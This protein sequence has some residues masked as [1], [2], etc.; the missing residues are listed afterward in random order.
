MDEQTSREREVVHDPMDDLARELQTWFGKEYSAAFSRRSMARI[1]D[2]YKPAALITFHQLGGDRSGAGGS[3][4]T[5]TIFTGSVFGA[6]IRRALPARLMLR[7]LFRRLA[8]QGYDHSI[9]SVAGIQPGETRSGPSHV[10]VLFTFDRIDRAGKT[11]ESS[12]AIYRVERIGSAWLISECWL[13]DSIASPPGSA[14]V[15]E[16]RG[17]SQS[18]VVTS[19]KSGCNYAWSRRTTERLVIWTRADGN[20]THPLAVAKPKSANGRERCHSRPLSRGADGTRT[21]GLRRDSS[22]RR[23]RGVDRRRVG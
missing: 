20:Q 8:K 19:P 10:K 1:L 15:A 7:V 14:A 2:F 6:L 23:S 3:G 13:F 11:F 18:V 5:L 4:K 16:P 21:R 9:I 17:V 12:A 22:A